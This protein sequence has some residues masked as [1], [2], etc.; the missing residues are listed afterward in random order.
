MEGVKAE[1]IMKCKPGHRRGALAGKRGH[2]S[3]REQE[4]H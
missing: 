1:Y 4:M 2:W 3:K